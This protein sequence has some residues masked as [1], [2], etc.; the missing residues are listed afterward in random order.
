MSLFGENLQYYR[1]RNNIT[2]EQLAEQLEVSR[3]TISKWES[4]A[5]YAEMEK[6]LQLCDLFSCG[7]DTLLRKDASISEI[8]DNL[9]HREHMKHFRKWITF[10]VALI[11][12]AAAFYELITGLRWMDEEVLNTVFMIIATVAIL[13][14]IVQGMKR[15]IPLTAISRQR[16]RP[17]SD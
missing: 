5:S 6:L 16:S 8:E 14:L 11:I 7:L 1:K 17:A 9:Q 12:F 13:I 4:G 15:K 2:Q 3:Q 10:G